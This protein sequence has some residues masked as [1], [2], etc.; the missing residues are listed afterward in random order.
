RFAAAE[1]A[2]GAATVIIR[3]TRRSSSVVR[4][5]R[6]RRL[7]PTSELPPRLSMKTVIGSR[8]PEVSSRICGRSRSSS[9]SLSRPSTEMARSGFGVKS[10]S[11]GKL[12]PGLSPH[13]FRA[14][15]TQAPRNAGGFG[16]ALQQRFTCLFPLRSDFASPDVELHGALERDTELAGK[17]RGTNALSDG[18][19]F[20]VF[21]HR[22]SFPCFVEM[23]PKPANA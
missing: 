15:P 19:D 22:G 6:L 21:R 8:L 11:S 10:A 4:L 12:V 18:F 3:E 14:Q 9:A 5:R 2:L 16:R 7:S 13:D 17:N 20:L 23:Q 1:A